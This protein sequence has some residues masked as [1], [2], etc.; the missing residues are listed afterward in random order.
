M[1]IGKIITNESGTILGGLDTVSL[2]Q[3][4]FSTKTMPIDY[5]D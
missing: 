1:K 4:R 5:K 3:T 2:K